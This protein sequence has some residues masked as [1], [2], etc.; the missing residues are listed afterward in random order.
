MGTSNL[1]LRIYDKKPDEELIEIASSSSYTTE[2]RK[3]AIDL[4]IK[5]GVAMENKSE[6]ADFQQELKNQS[7]LNV[8]S[9]ERLKYKTGSNRIIAAFLDSLILMVV[10]VFL[11]QFLN[12]IESTLF[13]GLISFVQVTIPYLYS[14]YLHGKFGQTVGKYLMKIK[15][16]D[17]SEKKEISY[18]QAILRD[19]IPFASVVVVQFISLFLNDQSN[20]FLHSLL[21]AIGAFVTIWTVLELI[22]MLFNKKRRALHDFIANTVVLRLES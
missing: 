20:G 1:F 11:I 3:I 21:A 5:R 9:L 16:Y 2:N 7:R 13:L 15:V 6:I 4:L 10:G 19:I 8:S 18:K 17:V 14:I 12:L 22:T